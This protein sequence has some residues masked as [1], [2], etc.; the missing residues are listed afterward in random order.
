MTQISKGSGSLKGQQ[1]PGLHQNRGSQQGGVS[2]CPHL[3]CL[4]KAPS[5]VL[6]PDLG[7]H[8]KAVELLEWVQRRAT[9]MI[10]YEDRLKELGLFSL[11]KR[12]L[13][14]DLTA[15]FQYF[16][17]ISRRETNTHFLDR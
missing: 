1:Y 13:W 3:L 5:E 6:H 2:D 16:L 15:A 12:R 9:K 4:C 14:G 11:E 8:K 17:L 10:S 7:L